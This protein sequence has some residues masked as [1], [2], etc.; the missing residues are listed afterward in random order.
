ME[1]HRCLVT[2]TTKGD[3]VPLG[4]WSTIE[5]H[6]GIL[7]AC[8][9]AIRTV[10][11]KVWPSVF[12][13]DQTYATGGSRS[14]QGTVQQV[15]SKSGRETPNFVRLVELPQGRHTPHSAMGSYDY[16]S[17]DHNQV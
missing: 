2:L 12:G 9:P 7:C 16:N 10:L 15:L 8:L 4:Y 1:I 11:R 6:V 5:V 3:N 14:S 13:G 17:Y